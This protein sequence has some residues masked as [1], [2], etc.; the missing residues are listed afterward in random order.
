[1]MMICVCLSVCVCNAV[2]LPAVYVCLSVCNLPSSIR[3]RNKSKATSYVCLSVCLSACLSVSVTQWSYRLC[4]CVFVC[5]L[6]CK[7][8]EWWST[9]LVIC[10]EWGANDLY[11]AQVRPLPPIIR[12]VRKSRIHNCRDYRDFRRVPWFFGHCH[13]FVSRLWI[14]AYYMQFQF[15]KG[16]YAQYFSISVVYR[17]CARSMLETRLAVWNTV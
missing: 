6:P 3:R 7:K 14:L 8:I 13:D 9:G 15:L 11:I 10:V 16:R 2:K 1:M 5:N 17:F 4:V 12:A